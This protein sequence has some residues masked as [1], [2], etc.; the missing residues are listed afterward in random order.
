LLD[1]ND[2]EILKI[3]QKNCKTPIKQIA[4]ELRVSQSTIHYRIKKLEAEKIIEGY[5]AK[6]DAAKLGKDFVTVTSLR[7]KHGTRDHKSIGALLAQI[8]GVSVVYFVFGD[9]DFV[10]LSKSDSSRDFMNKLEKV[11]NTKE[12]ERSSTQI[13]AKIIREDTRIE[14]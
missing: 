3:L 10:V 13:V 14:I 5:Y 8:P 9:N 7:T 1:E 6:V 4:N 11:M 12:I 2:K